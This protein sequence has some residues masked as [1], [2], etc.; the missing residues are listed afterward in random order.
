MINIYIFIIYKCKV[1]YR[2]IVLC[3]IKLLQEN[4]GRGKWI[5]F[6]VAYKFRDLSFIPENNE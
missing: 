6:T 1:V 5:F 3:Y 2:S 4:N